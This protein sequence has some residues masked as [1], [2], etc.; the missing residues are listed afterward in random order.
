MWLNWFLLVL[1]QFLD[2]EGF[3]PP[4]CLQISLPL[5]NVFQ[6]IKDEFV[7]NCVFTVPF[8]QFT[9]SL[10]NKSIVR[11]KDVYNKILLPTNV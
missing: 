9:M 4:L 1:V 11:K 3:P 8:D 2:R 6:R 7:K 10:L 5:K